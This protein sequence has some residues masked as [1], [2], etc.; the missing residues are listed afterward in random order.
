V[1]RADRRRA[2]RAAGELIPL[3]SNHPFAIARAREMMAENPAVPWD[4]AI[5]AAAVELILERCEFLPVGFSRE[6]WLACVL[7][8]AWP[9]FHCDTCGSKAVQGAMKRLGLIAAPDYAAMRRGQP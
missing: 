2:S 8:F 6:G 4:L 7:A 9:E 5:G 1:S 3:S